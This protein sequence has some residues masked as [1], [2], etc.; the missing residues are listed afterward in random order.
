MKNNLGPTLVKSMTLAILFT[1]SA[2]GCLA[3]QD[4]GGGRLEGTWDAQVSITNCATGDTIVTFPSIASFM[5]GGTS[6]GSTGGMPQSLR[7]PEH[8][9]WAH[10]KANTYEFRFKTFSF[11]AQNIPI[12]WSIVRHTVV[13]DAKGD[14]YTSSGTAQH[15]APNGVQLGSGCSTAVGTRFTL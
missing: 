5:Q 3:Q 8:G 15:F 12:G 9:V 4:N 2:V 6:I 7:T 1:L 10:V 13:L 14:T 11:N